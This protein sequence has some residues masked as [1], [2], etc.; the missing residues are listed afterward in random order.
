M[1]TASFNPEL[2]A[3]LVEGFRKYPNNYRQAGLFAGVT[4]RTAK[5]YFL[6]QSKDGERWEGFKPIAE[7]IKE[8]EEA[9]RIE[10]QRKEEALSAERDRLAKEAEKA[11]ALEEEAKTIDEMAVRALRKDTLAGLVACAAITD[12]IQKLAVRIG[13]QLATGVDAQGK[14]LNIDVS[15]ALRTMRDY[16]LTVGRLGAIVETIQA[17]ER[18]KNN[19][20]TAIVGIDVSHV[21]LEDAE[22]E[23]EFA[24]GA[25]QRARE[26]GLIV[27]EGGEGKKTG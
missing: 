5:R 4:D 17:M 10:R 7:L 22:R 13:N 8:N 24:Q 11:R 15:K 19:L 25:L 23:V 2:Y 26:L 1:A 27:H 3:K 6:G 9:A 16:S 18:V 14:P 21:T 20:P 12:G